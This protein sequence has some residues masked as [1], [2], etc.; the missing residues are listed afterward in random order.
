MIHSVKRLE[1]LSAASMEL[2]IHIETRENLALLG[3]RTLRR[4][5]TELTHSSTRDR[6]SK[7]SILPEAELT[8]IVEILSDTP[9]VLPCYKKAPLPHDSI[10]DGI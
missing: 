3:S 10:H 7:T 1:F 8:A 5:Q 9:D 6:P 4:E 2:A